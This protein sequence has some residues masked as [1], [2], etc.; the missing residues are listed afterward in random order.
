MASTNNSIDFS[1]TVSDYDNHMIGDPHFPQLPQD[2]L[3]DNTA[4]K[5]NL[6]ACIS[7]S[8]EIEHDQISKNIKKTNFLKFNILG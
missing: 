4:L 8:S 6:S 7:P 2:S 5:F 1:S 3:M